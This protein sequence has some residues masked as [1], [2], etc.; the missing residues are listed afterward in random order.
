MNHQGTKKLETKRLIL[1]KF[2]LED[3]EET[4]SSFEEIMRLM[5]NRTITEEVFVDSIKRNYVYTRIIMTH[6][7]K[8]LEVYHIMCDRSQRA[9]DARHWRVLESL[10]IADDY[11]TADRIAQEEH[12]DR[13]TVYKDIDV[14]ISDLT[15]LM[16]GV[17][18]IERLK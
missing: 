8:M 10:Y 13:R 1:R 3:A 12:I 14:C 7:N 18:G 16:F 15:A 6:V 9:D 4:D 2:T 17:S 11:T 5:Q